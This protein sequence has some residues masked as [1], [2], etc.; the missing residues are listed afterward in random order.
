MRFI[1][2]VDRH[3]IDAMDVLRKSIMQT[4]ELRGK[5]AKREEPQ[6]F[7]VETTGEDPDGWQPGTPTPRRNPEGLDENKQI[8]HQA[9][10]ENWRRF[11]K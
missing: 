4:A 1:S 3:F 2:W 9:L 7:K 5:T 10:F 6:L 8:T 11:I